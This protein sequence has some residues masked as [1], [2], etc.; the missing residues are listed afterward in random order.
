MSA[1]CPPAEFESARTH[2]LCRVFPFF[3]TQVGGASM[4][5]AGDWATRRYVGIRFFRGIDHV[6]FGGYPTCANAPLGGL[7][8][9]TPSNSNGILV[10]EKRSMLPLP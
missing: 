8:N 4:L 7:D 6:W 1:V 10:K 3:G 5:V 2:K 9:G